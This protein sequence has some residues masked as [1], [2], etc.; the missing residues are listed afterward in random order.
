MPISSTRRFRFIYSGEGDSFTNMALDEA[1]LIGLQKEISLPLLRIYKWNPPTITIGYFQKS[2]DIDFE[3]C[4]NDGIGIVRRL[5]GGRAVL[6][7]EELTYSILFS[8][9]DFTPFTKKDIFAYVAQCLVTSLSVLGI[10]SNIARKTRGDLRSADCFASP[11]QFEIE[12]AGQEK[13]IGSAQ[14]IKDGV[15][16][17]HG[18][19]PYSGAY[20]N[21][22]KYLK[23]DTNSPKSASFLSR[24]AGEKIGEE[25]LLKA[26]KEGFHRHLPIID[27]KLTKW[28]LEL[29]RELAK[30]KYSKSEWMFK[31]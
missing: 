27:G 10:S 22:E 8:K 5:T 30:N 28:E 29:T 14:V 9:E 3:R 7:W 26:L 23:C 21:I 6:H 18:S 12:S 31:R 4:R 2:S 15:V 20:A 17:Q 16:L 11:A 1:V 19:I 24:I 13:L 25:K